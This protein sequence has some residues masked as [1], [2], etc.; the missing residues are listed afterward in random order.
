MK[1]GTK[2]GTI[3]AAPQPEG[4]KREHEPADI[5]Y[6]FHLSPQLQAGFSGSLF[7]GVKVTEYSFASGK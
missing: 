1:V 5:E 6:Q 4:R 2:S 3:P 7:R